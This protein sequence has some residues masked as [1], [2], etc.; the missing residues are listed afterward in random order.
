VIDRSLVPGDYRVFARIAD[1]HLMKLWLDLVAR[2]AIAATDPLPGAGA[3]PAGPVDRPD[4]QPSPAG[5]KDDCQVV[6]LDGARLG[7]RCCNGDWLVI[8]AP[9]RTALEFKCGTEARTPRLRSGR[10]RGEDVIFLDQGG[11]AAIELPARLSGGR[12]VPVVIGLTRA[13][14]LRGAAHL[15]ATQRRGDGELSAGYS[16]VG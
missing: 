16:V 1:P 13:G 5:A 2:G 7:V 15:L 11:A 3:Q 9:A 12:F 14:G 10:V 4:D 6:L 8:H